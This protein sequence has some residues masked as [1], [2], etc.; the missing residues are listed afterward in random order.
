[1]GYEYRVLHE[2]DFRNLESKLNALGKVNWKP[3]N[4][5]WDND[6]ESP[7]MVTLIKEK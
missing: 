1:M 5:F 6:D 7:L 4:V 2:S 3:V